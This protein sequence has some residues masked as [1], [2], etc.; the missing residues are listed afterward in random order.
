VKKF[1][2]P[3]HYCLRQSPRFYAAVDGVVIN[4]TTNKPQAGATVTL[5]QTTN[6]GAANFIDSVKTGPDGKF[7]INKDVQPGSR[8]RAGSA[9]G[10]LWRCFSTTRSSRPGQSVNGVEV[11]VFRILQTGRGEAKIDQHFMVLDPSADGKR[12]GRRN[13]R[14]IRIPARPPG[15]D[16]DRGTLQFALPGARLREKLK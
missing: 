12:Y 15:N 9:A 2:S 4:G 11:P 14:F 13:L 1:I 10:G 8:R 5:F 3:R 6:Q 7:V 16:P